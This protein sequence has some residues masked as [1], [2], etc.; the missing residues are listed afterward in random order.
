MDRKISLPRHEV[1]A[2]GLWYLQWQK[3]FKER[4][5]KQILSPQAFVDE[6][7]TSTSVGSK[8]EL[9]GK[10]STASLVLLPK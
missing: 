6:H 4:L 7:L 9:L 10:S 2:I 5:R 3:A 1:E 8:G